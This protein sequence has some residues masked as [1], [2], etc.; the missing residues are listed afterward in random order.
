MHPATKRR[1]FLLCSFSFLV[2][3][4]AVYWFT[5]YCEPLSLV[6]RQIDEWSSSTWRLVP[7]ARDEGVIFLKTHKTAGSTVT[8]VMWH[9]LCALAKRNCFLSPSSHPGKTWDF[10]RPRDWRIMRRLGGSSLF[11]NGTFPYSVWLFH[12]AYSTSLF[13]VVEHTHRMISIVRRPCR[14]FES[15]WHWY[16]HSSTLNIGLDRFARNS[17]LYAPH[18]KY[19]TGLDATTEELTGISDFRS[20]RFLQRSGYIELLNR[21]AKQS[22]VLLVAERFD[23]SLLVLGR[24]MGWSPSQLVSFKQKVGNY[25]RV[26]EDAC[27]L[28]DD[29]Q[30]FDLGVWKLA[31][32]ALSK[33]ISDNFAQNEFSQQLLE[34]TQLNKQLEE[35]CSGPNT[36]AHPECDLRL[37]NHA[38]IQRVW[39]TAPYP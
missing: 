1:W 19:R 29:M 16:N 11:K 31:N 5:L 30:P 20:K 2:V 8:S 26:G 37:D 18:F 27:L 9:N 13:S 4:R 15:A 7:Y 35:K 6:E 24:L 25:Q 32:A 22:L 23:E 39:K 33:Y 17:S 38:R 28:L 12:A 10:R 14:R 36:N 3:L 21:V 34:L